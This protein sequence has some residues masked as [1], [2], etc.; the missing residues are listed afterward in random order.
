MIM[1]LLVILPQM[2]SQPRC[3]MRTELPSNHCVCRQ[4][5]QNSIRSAPDGLY[6]GRGLRVNQREVAH[7]CVP[8]L[9]HFTQLLGLSQLPTDGIWLQNIREIHSHCRKNNTK[10][11][12]RCLQSREECVEITHMESLASLNVE[13]D[14]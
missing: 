11:C 12:M 6:R 9:V 1:S 13:L 10:S 7:L 5:Q 3:T 14:S 4:D 8:Q 2:F